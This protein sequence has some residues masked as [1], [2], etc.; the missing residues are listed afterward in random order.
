[1]RI[2]EV[3]KKKA[4]GEGCTCYRRG[5]NQV[6]QVKTREKGGG[7]SDLLLKIGK[8]NGATAKTGNNL[9]GSNWRKKCGVKR[10][11]NK[12]KEVAKK[13]RKTAAGQR[14]NEEKER[15][16]GQPFVRRARKKN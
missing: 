8:K 12:Q 7:P 5:V 16:A 3:E 9:H 6:Y 4:Q 15:S 10:L 1:L 11:T 14:G 13:I 2:L